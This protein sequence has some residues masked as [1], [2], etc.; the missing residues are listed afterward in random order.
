MH[1]PLIPTLSHQIITLK[2]PSSSSSSNQ[3]TYIVYNIGIRKRKCLSVTLLVNYEF[4]LFFCFASRALI[5]SPIML[6]YLIS[7]QVFWSVGFPVILS[8]QDFRIIYIYV[9]L[10]WW[11]SGCGGGKYITQDCFLFFGILLLFLSC[12]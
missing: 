11:N 4:F 1:K 12:L 6:F 10:C 7:F 5:F 8:K 3:H 2:P 9:T